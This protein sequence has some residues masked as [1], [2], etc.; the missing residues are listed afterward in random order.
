MPRPLTSSLSALLSL[1]RR[2]RVSAARSFQT[3]ANK[4]TFRDFEDV[5]SPDLCYDT[6]LWRYR[7]ANVGK[8]ISS[9]RSSKMATLSIRLRSPRWMASPKPE[10]PMIAQ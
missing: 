5:R 2:S 7:S 3:A 6:Q 9:R 10:L 8:L 1:D 4:I